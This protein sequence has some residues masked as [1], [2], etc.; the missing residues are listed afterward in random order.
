MPDRWLSLPD[1]T[2]R[3]KPA[4]GMTLV[5]E[6]AKADTD[7]NTSPTAAVYRA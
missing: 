7:M 3:T 6:E 1:L 4:S 2:I 5:G